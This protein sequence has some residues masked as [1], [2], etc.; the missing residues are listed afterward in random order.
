[1]QYREPS[2]RVDQVAHCVI[3]AAIQVHRSLGP[4]LL[5]S[6]YQTTLQIELRHAG[7]H[8]Q[9]H[10]PIPIEYRGEVAGIYEL[11]L[12]VEEEL[13]VELKSVAKLADIHRAQLLTYLRATNLDLGLLIN[14][15][16]AYLR[17]GLA[18]VVRGGRVLGRESGPRRES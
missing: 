15:N 18:R 5:E 11:D 17:E 4:G 2:A 3:G 7:L 1:M 13:V 8:A 10:A 16:V 9:R 6:I 14:F 12:L